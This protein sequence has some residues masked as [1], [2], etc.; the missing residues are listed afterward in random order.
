MDM[1][2]QDGGIKLEDVFGTRGVI[3]LCRYLESHKEG[4]LTVRALAEQAG[5]PPSQGNIAA[6][7]MQEMGIIS[8]EEVGKAYLVTVN[9]KSPVWQGI[10]VPILKVEKNIK[11]VMS[12]PMAD[13][14]RELSGM[15]I[16]SA[17]L[18]NV[19]NKHASLFIS[20]ANEINKRQV[21]RITSSLLQKMIEIKW[22]HT[23]KEQTR[24]FARKIV[25]S[26]NYRVIIGPDPFI[27]QY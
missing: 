7:A 1:R 5:V 25:T 27:R 21:M 3:T 10:I 6:K 15:G 13:L 12:D 23:S 4:K 14:K 22:I 18:Y 24:Y 20:S 8:L 17:I 16:N 11:K 19:D 26:N 9:R 2:T